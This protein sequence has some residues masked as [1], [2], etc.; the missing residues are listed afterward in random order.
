MWSP[1]KRSTCHGQLL[2]VASIPP[3]IL[4]PSSLGLTAG[5]PQTKAGALKTTSNSVKYQ[6]SK[7][8]FQLFT[9]GC[10]DRCGCSGCGDCSGRWKN[11]WFISWRSDKA[12]IKG[13]NFHV[14]VG[15]AS[16]YQQKPFAVECCVFELFS[17]EKPAKAVDKIVSIDNFNVV[18]FGAVDLNSTKLYL[19]YLSGQNRIFNKFYKYIYLD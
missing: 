5:A 15:F 9:F 4:R 6:N 1:S 19:S 18:A 12:R 7:I 8:E 10:S 3:T 11:G 2:G 13:V 17:N 16:D 14:K